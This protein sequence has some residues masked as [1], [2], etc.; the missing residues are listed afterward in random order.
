MALYPLRFKPRLKERIWGGESL[1][2][3]CGKRSAKG[4]RYGESWE[5]SGVAGDLSV[6]SSGMFK[7]NDL[8]EMVEIYMGDLVGEKV[9]DKF[10]IEFPLLVKHIDTAALLSI[11]VHPD[12]RLAAERHNSYGKTEV[13]YV[14]EC[15]PG[16]SLYLGLKSGVTRAQYLDAVVAGTLP[17]LLQKYEVHAGDAF[18]IPAGTIHAIGKGIKVVE[19]QQTSDITYRIFDWNRV[20]DNGRPRQLHTALAIDAIDFDS[21][22]QYVITRPPQKNT[23]VKIVCCP[24]FTTNLLEVEGEVERDFSSL[25]SFVI[26]VCVEGSVALSC[27]GAEECL[28]KD[29]VLL[30]PAEQMAV[31][32]KGDGTL[33]EVYCEY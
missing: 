15:E 20:D 22:A 19:I 13:W 12:D 26:Y 3:K 18:F 11:Q 4:K 21:D 27:E 7:G 8:Q 24:Y 33:L 30:V 9:Y 29:D 23:P 1:A 10:G 17:E 32:L 14:T 28:S 2:A 6:V 25:D 31:T 16:A 5:I